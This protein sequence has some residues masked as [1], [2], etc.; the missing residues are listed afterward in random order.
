M[1]GEKGVEATNWISLWDRAQIFLALLPMPIVFAWSLLK[2]PFSPYGRAKSWKRILADRFVLMITTGMNRRQTRHVFGTTRLTY[3][4]FVKEAKLSPVVEDIGDG[5]KLLWLGPKRT[6]RVLLYFHGGAFLYAM[7][8]AAPRFWRYIQENLE[9]RG[10]D[11]GFAILNYTLVPDRTFP[12]QLRQAVR[13]IQYLMDSGVKPENMQ[14]VGDSAG[15]TLIHEVFSHMLHPVDTVPQLSLCCPFAGA[16]FVSPW[17]RLVDKDG[18]LHT[19]DN[20]G[21]FLTG[22]SLNYWGSKVLRGIPRAAIP[23]LEPNSAPSN[24]LK[25]VG[26]CT[27]RVFI[28]A[29]GVECLRDEIIRY[30]HT[31]RT[32]HHDVTFIMQENGAHNDPYTDFLTKEKDLG[33]VT[34]RV[35]DW[36]EENFTFSTV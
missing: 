32:R 1:G 27:R 22:K 33:V 4:E 31:F 19:N 3:D 23:Y 25:G 20:N 5:A 34:P 35:L 2:A 10:T 7:P 16:L 21:D 14:I 6:D 11:V 24:W 12:T 26:R 36:L 15:G 30:Q 28:T 9:K 13:A 29:G 8:L 17:V 18:C